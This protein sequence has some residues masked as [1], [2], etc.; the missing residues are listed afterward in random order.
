MKFHNLS[1]DERNKL[2][3]LTKNYDL[4]ETKYTYNEDEDDDLVNGLIETPSLVVI[5][6]PP[7]TGKTLIAID[8]AVSLSSSKNWLGRS[9]PK[10]ANIIYLA[11]EDPKS[12]I[13]RMQCTF[14]NKFNLDNYLENRISISKQP[15][16]ILDEHYEEALE[17]YFSN[18]LNDDDTNVKLK[19]VLI[20]DTLSMAM[21]GRGDENSSTGMGLAIEKFRNIRN[22]GIT[23]IVITHSGKD[24]TK[25]VRGHNSLTAAA[26]CIFSV[27]KKP[28]SNLIKLKRTEYRN[29]PAGETFSL[30]IKTGILKDDSFSNDNGL[31]VPYLQYLQD[32]NNED[33]KDTMTKP[34]IIVLNSI[35]RLMDTETTNIREIFNLQEDQLAVAYSILAE[36][37]INRNIAPKAKS[38]AS[39]S[40]AVKRALDSLIGKGIISER[41]DFI[42]IAPLAETTPDKIKNNR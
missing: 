7:K 1:N 40:R 6:G 21:A 32:S 35:Q 42:W 11:Y 41:G 30:E 10:P 8:L 31:R 37:C 38:T 19:H 33:A 25:G 15:P 3:K 36:D 2:I 29:G 34:Q 12:I 20:V 18:Y 28:T 39:K 14:K 26:D 5:Y 24:I 22:L 17:F 9:I 16:D 13:R 27:G 23:V 4:F